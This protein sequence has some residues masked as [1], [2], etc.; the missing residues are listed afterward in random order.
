MNRKG[1]KRDLAR[2]LRSESGSLGEKQSGRNVE[3]G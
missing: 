1:I 3:G 2:R